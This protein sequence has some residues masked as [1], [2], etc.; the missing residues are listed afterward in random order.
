MATLRTPPPAAAAA[1]AFMGVHA[2]E[3][4]RSHPGLRS[5]QRPNRPRVLVCCAKRLRED[6]GRVAKLE[7]FVERARQR[8]RERAL[9][10]NERSVLD[11]LQELHNRQVERHD[12][13]AWCAT[14]PLDEAQTNRLKQ[15]LRAPAFCERVAKQS[16]A[17]HVRFADRVVSCAPEPGAAGWVLDE[18]TWAVL[19]SQSRFT[20][21]AIPPFLVRLAVPDIKWDADGLSR[22][23]YAL[24]ALYEL[25]SCDYSLYIDSLE[26]RGASTPAEFAELRRRFEAGYLDIGNSLRTE[27]DHQNFDCEHELFAESLT[28]WLERST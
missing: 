21:V 10:P 27:T 23:H 9:K 11:H 26:E 3:P 17:D 6:A 18:A 20:L 28:D 4:C 25:P 2:M 19:A 7:N 1:A 5:R 16:G 24:G 14:F 8:R 22:A 13:A 12:D 15:V